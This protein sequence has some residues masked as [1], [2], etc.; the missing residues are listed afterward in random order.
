M[1]RAALTAIAPTAYTVIARRR[2]PLAAI[3]PLAE[4]ADPGA[5]SGRT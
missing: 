3:T 2:R 4:P 1:R 5:V